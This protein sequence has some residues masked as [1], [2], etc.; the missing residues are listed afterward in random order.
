MLIIEP[1]TITVICS[2]GKPV[3]EDDE[4]ED[5]SARL[6]YFKPV[7]AGV[8][9]AEWHEE[10]RNRIRLGGLVLA[11]TAFWAVAVFAGLGLWRYLRK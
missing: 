2:L 10:L 5:T 11:T 4:E 1:I 6:R 8:L 7:D 9:R 3:F